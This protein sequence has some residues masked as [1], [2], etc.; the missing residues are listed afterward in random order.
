MNRLLRNNI[1]KVSKF[2]PTIGIGAKIIL[3]YVLLTLVIA[4][5]GTFVLLNLVTSSFQDR[6]NNQLIDAGRIVS[7]GIVQSEGERLQVLRTVAGTIGVPE[8]VANKDRDTLAGLVPQIIINSEADAVELLDINGIEIY[9]W[10]QPVGVGKNPVERSN[11]NLSQIEDVRLVLDGTVDNLGDKRVFLS[12]TPDGILVF[13]VGPIMLNGEQV[14]AVMIGTD[15][16]SMAI[17]LTLNAVARITFY[18]RRGK[19]LQTTLGGGQDEIMDSVEESPELYQQVT[20]QLETEPVIVENPESKT[21][22]RQIEIFNQPYQL[23]FGDWRL[24][25]QSFGMFSV[26]LPRNFLVTTVVNGRNLFVV[27]FS[28]ATVAVFF[29]GIIISRRLA[30]PIHMLVE[31]AKAV[32]AGNLDQRSNIQG[33]DEIGQL[34]AAFDTMTE[35]L[36]QRNRQLL[37]KASEL[38]AIVDSIADGVIVINTNDEIVTLNPAAKQLLSDMSHDFFQGPMRELSQSF[39]VGSGESVE[40]ELS[41]VVSSR[42]PRRYQVGNRILGANGAVVTTPNGEKIGSVVVLRDITREVEADS[43][44]DAFITSISHE[45]RTPLTVIKVYA[46]LMKS[47]AN[48]HLDDRQLSFIKNINKG[49]QELEHHINQLINISEIQAGTLNLSRVEINFA[50]FV[51]DIGERWHKKFAEKDLLFEIESAKDTLPVQADMSHLTWAIENLL[52]NAHTYTLRGGKVKLSIFSDAQSA[53]LAVSDNGIGIAAADQ[54]HLYDRF[55]RA[56][57]VENYE[58]RGVGLGLFITKSI[59][60]LHGGHISVESESGV[61][62]TFTVSIPLVEEKEHDIQ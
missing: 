27:I 24:R 52:S 6:I 44:K 38:E 17:D 33:K 51:M 4:S 55:F 31:T 23:A 9:G 2:M 12:E 34:A 54:P 18:D 13:T 47:S 37:E 7:E 14:G 50:G 11:A 58:S 53:F 46:D 29:G 40:S 22:L 59:I 25:S 35:T 45:L 16:R 26:A 10:Q 15:L 57:N 32:T 30:R 21:P 61:G 1:A 28:L 20:S 41:T 19:V 43:L 5:V 3:P 36:G 62:S 56:H 48:G 39:T 8:A 42:K 49:S 60:E